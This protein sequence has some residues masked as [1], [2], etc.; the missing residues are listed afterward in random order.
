MPRRVY[1]YLDQLGWA[2]LNLTASIGAGMGI[3]GGIQAGVVVDAGFPLG[4]G[5]RARS[6]AEITASVDLSV[7][8]RSCSPGIVY[9]DEF[10]DNLEDGAWTVA[11]YHL[12]IPVPNDLAGRV[13]EMIRAGGG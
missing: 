13:V 5:A 1:T 6:G 4:I 2:G 7:V 11:Q 10:I 3:Y 8:P 12:T 9:L